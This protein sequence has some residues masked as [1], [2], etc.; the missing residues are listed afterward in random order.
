MAW[1]SAFILAEAAGFALSSLLTSTSPEALDVSLG[2]SLT[3]VVRMVVIVLLAPRTGVALSNTYRSPP[4]KRLSLLAGVIVSTGV[5][6]YLVN[7]SSIPVGSSI[8]QYGNFE[9]GGALWTVPFAGGYYLSEI[10]MLNFLYIL[11]KSSW[12]LLGSP[13]LAAI[14]FLMLGWA[15]LH[16][17]TQGLATAIF[18]LA[19]V[20]IF[21]V[22][23]EYTGKSPIA[24]ILL[25][26]VTVVF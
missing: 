6:A 9:I 20:P 5:L 19:L 7:L 4:P 3:I 11:A 10:I 24:P 22:S 21:Y 14:V 16:V 25:W 13:A 17:I 18:G 1:A 15:S 23:Y 12:S 26:F 2:Q 8:I